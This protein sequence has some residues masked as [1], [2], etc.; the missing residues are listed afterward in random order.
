MFLKTLLKK[1]EQRF[2][3]ATGWIAEQS[4]Y[5][6]TQSYDVMKPGLTHFPKMHK[7]ISHFMTGEIGYY[8]YIVF[9]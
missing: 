7:I 6:T 9:K 5:V 1:D 8:R 3:Q 2:F 4:W